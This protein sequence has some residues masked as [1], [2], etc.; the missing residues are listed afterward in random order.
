MQK[1]VKHLDVGATIIKLLQKNKRKNCVCRLGNG[2]LG[3][4]PE[5]QAAKQERDKLDLL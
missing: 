2:S 3:V 1:W 5:A 4:T